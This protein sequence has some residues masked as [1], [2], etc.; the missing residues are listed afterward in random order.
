M[1]EFNGIV[2]CCLRIRSAVNALPVEESDAFVQSK[3]IAHN[4]HGIHLQSAVI[5]NWPFLPIRA[6]TIATLA[7]PIIVQ[8]LAKNLKV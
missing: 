8:I 5:G 1:L 7:K 4:S 6:G 2:E 3:T